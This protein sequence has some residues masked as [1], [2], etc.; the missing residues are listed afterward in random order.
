MDRC[1]LCAK[2]HNYFEICLSAIEIECSEISYH[3]LQSIRANSSFRYRNSRDSKG[4]DYPLHQLYE[5]M[6]NIN[7]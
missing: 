5:V 6:E 2:K 3:E 1:V 7:A 4:K